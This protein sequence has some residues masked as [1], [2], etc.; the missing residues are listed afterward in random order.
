MGNML[1][2]ILFIVG[3]ILATAGVVVLT[4]FGADVAAPS[5]ARNKAGWTGLA[6]LL[7]GVCLMALMAL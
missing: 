2:N 7:A 5:E 6:C 4:T 3:A 1:I